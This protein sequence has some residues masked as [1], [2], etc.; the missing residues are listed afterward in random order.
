MTPPEPTAARWSRGKTPVFASRYDQRFSYCLY[1]P[2]D[3]GPDT[4]V[5]VVVHGT[6][7]NFLL[8]RDHL[9]PFADEHG[10][11][12]LAPLFP[13]GINDP[14]DLHSYK[15]LDHQGIRYDQVLLAMVDEVAQRYP[16]DAGKFYLHGFSGGGQF[17]HRFFYLH[18]DRLA[19]V[20]IGAPGRITR[21]DDTLPWWL[22]TADFEKTFGQPIDVDA[23]RRV[24]V[25]MVVGDQDVE[26]WEITNPGE[27]NWMAGA[28]LTGDTR[29]ERLKTLERDFAALG[30]TV[31]FVLVPGV[32]HRGSQVLP[33]VRDFFAELIDARRRGEEPS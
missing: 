33:P 4:P 23:L 14:G 21:L 31:R 25:L 18:P 11:V 9:Q 5:V 24:P 16:V 6:E 7:R 22:G 32:A 15:F 13:A 28:E 17:A 12:V 30:I 2:D 20:S 1:V 26:T 19:G 29:I 3:L 8:Y 10:A 27:P